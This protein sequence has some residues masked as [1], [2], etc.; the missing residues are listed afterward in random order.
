MRFE[1]HS[2]FQCLQFLTPGS[3]S[4]PEL[5][6]KESSGL[7]LPTKIESTKNKVPEKTLIIAAKYISSCQFL[8]GVYLHSTDVRAVYEIIHPLRIS[9]MMMISAVSFFLSFAYGWKTHWTH[10]CGIYL[11]F[12]WFK[13]HIRKQGNTTSRIILFPSVC[14]GACFSSYIG[15]IRGRYNELMTQTTH[16]MVYT[17]NATDL[18]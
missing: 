3:V 10:S 9:L 11:F 7:V 13:T 15:V 6:C 8:G 5:N 1:A 16:H 4:S 17:L 14:V 12:C 2:K 18:I